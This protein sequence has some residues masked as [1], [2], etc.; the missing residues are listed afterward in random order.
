[1]I[2]ITGAHGKLG[3]ELSKLYPNALKPTHK[4][5]DITN[6]KQVFEYIKKHM[7]NTIIHLAALTG[8]RQCEENK[9]LAWETNVLGTKN[10]IDACLEH[11]PS[12]YFIYMSTPCFTK[13]TL[14]LTNFSI[15]PISL[16][17]KGE[18]V[19]THK[20]NLKKVVKTFKRKYKGKILK[21]KPLGNLEIECTPNHPFLA[22]K[23]KYKKNYKEDKFKNIIKRKP[24]WI[25][26]GDLNIGDMLV[27]PK[28]KITGYAPRFVKI[29]NKRL[30][31]YYEIMKLEIPRYES[32]KIKR[33]ILSELS[34][35]YKINKLVLSGWINK[36]HK[37]K[38]L[39]N[40]KIK[41]DKNLSY[42]FGIFV[43]EGWIQ[44]N[45]R[46]Y[47]KRKKYYSS[48][49]LVFAFGEEP[50][51]IE[52]TKKI[53]RQKFNIDAKIEKMKNQKG[54][55]LHIVDK[56]IANLFEKLFY[57]KNGHRAWNKK[58]PNWFLF[59][60]KNLISAFLKGYWDG[61]GSIW[62]GQHPFA[63][64]STVSFKLINQIKLLLLKLGIYPCLIKRKPSSQILGRKVK[65]KESFQLIISGK[66]IKKFAKLL[67]FSFKYEP[68]YQKFIETKDYFLVPITKIEIEDFNG[69]VFNLEVLDD[70]SYLS[71]YISVHNCVFS[72][73]PK[74]AP[75]TENSFPYPK[76]F[77]SLTK[78]LGEMAVRFT[79]LRWLVIRG[80][81]VPR[82]KWLYPKA[83][84]DRWGTYL[85]ADQLAMAIKEV[86]EKGL[87]GIVHLVGDKK[88]SMYEL[89]KM[90]TPDI[91]P[92][93]LKE[94]SG[95]PL[96]QDMSLDTII[97]HKYKID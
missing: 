2:F 77:Y 80:N 90:T 85:F 17:R 63:S 81:F 87:C 6:R 7:P 45:K 91:E 97:W 26:A 31:K 58:L 46:F 50:N 95:P 25:L 37:P 40:L 34:K 74:E 15:K 49:E 35:K 72:G 18:K 93:T 1:M 82:A 88:L 59:L 23:R 8:I 61:D 55:K 60:N 24:K 83:F 38:H 9:K 71:S 16:I 62:Q 14:I 5:L 66:Q 53:L 11:N 78:L 67:G 19:I 68:K 96:T 92:M 44:Y 76:N 28:I 86:V 21:I 52:K 48:K 47:K 32:G 4:E 89:A 10:L 84:T 39:I 65:D 13:N 22:I 57:N 42:L 27:V 36:K 20:G 29:S 51:L 94:Y 64:C 43:A 41:I 54:Y 69:D 30:E 33:G 73:N 70:N 3:S 12:V 75:F 79:D 56:N